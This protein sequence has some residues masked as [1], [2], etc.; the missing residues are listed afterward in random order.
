L[1]RLS[2]SL[3]FLSAAI[4][5]PVSSLSY[6]SL[7]VAALLL[8]C[9][10]TIFGVTASCVVLAL[11]AVPQVWRAGSDFGRLL[12]ITFGTFFFLLPCYQAFARLLLPF[13]VVVM[14]LAGYAMKLFF[15]SQTVQ[16]ACE[17]FFAGRIW[18]RAASVTGAAV[19]AILTTYGLRH[20]QPHSWAAETGYR[21]AAQQV[22]SAVPANGAVFVIA[23]PEV[24]FYLQSAGRQTFCICIDPQT[25]RRYQATHPFRSDR[26]A[27]QYVVAGFYAKEWWNWSP[28]TANASSPYRLLARIPAPPSDI[29]LLDD[30]PTQESRKAP[31]SLQS[32]YDLYLY[33]HLPG[34]A[35]AS[36]TP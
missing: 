6:I 15:E 19:L 4:F 29:R 34:E 23:E 28:A 1:S 10:S 14:L 25:Y 18:R 11:V 16:R 24:A 20:A 35:V 5:S 12:V 32:M 27:P 9:A 7:I 36:S 3:A 31:G 8:L 17:Q 21:D 33:K 13:S 22:A 30:F 26:N 2:P